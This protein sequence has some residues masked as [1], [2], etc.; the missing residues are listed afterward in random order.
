[1]RNTTKHNLPLC[2]VS[3]VHMCRCVF[4]FS[5]GGSE[6]TIVS[7]PSTSILK[8]VLLCHFLCHFTCF[9]VESQFGE[10][11]RCWIVLVKYH[12]VC[13]HQSLVQFEFKTTER[14][15]HKTANETVITQLKLYARPRE[16]NLSLWERENFLSGDSI[17]KGQA[18]LK[19]FNCSGGRSLLLCRSD[20]SCQKKQ[21]LPFI[22][23]VSTAFVTPVW[24]KS[25]S[26]PNTF[27]VFF[28][29]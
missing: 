11:T 21:I 3:A 13:D 15:D 19:S 24:L 9:H 8:F 7:F 20:G 26:Q 5:G 28:K 10:K 6:Q 17:S 27:L 29:S 1:M 23:F 25:Q 4:P 14:L 18:R 22:S 16:C 2:R 12:V